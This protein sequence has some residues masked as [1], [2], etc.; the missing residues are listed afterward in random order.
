[1]M[2]FLVCRNI[3]EPQSISVNRRHSCLVNDRK[4]IEGAIKQPGKMTEE[5]LNIEHLEFIY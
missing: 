1:M 2:S 4:G 5:V 3:T